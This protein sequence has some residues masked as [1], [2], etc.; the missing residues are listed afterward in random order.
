MVTIIFKLLCDQDLD[1]GEKFRIL[2][3]VNLVDKCDIFW[4]QH[5][6]G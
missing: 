1:I 5:L 2:I 3:Y 6:F 4:D